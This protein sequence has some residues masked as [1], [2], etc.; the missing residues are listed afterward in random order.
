MKG[1]LWL[2]GTKE[3]QHTIKVLTITHNFP[4]MHLQYSTTAYVSRNAQFINDIKAG[5]W[6]IYNL[7]LWAY[8]ISFDIL[9]FP[10]HFLLSAWVVGLV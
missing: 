6:W 9:E 3:F 5:W 1:C 8:Q 2:A 7:D 4:I 10:Q